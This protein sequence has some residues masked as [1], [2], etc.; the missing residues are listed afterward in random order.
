M[1]NISPQ[2]LNIIILVLAVIGA[3]F[4]LYKVAGA[5]L[6][7]VGV[8]IILGLVIYFWQGGTVDGLKGKGTEMLFKNTPIAQLEETFCA[9][10]K[11]TNAKCI[12]M[13]QPVLEDLNARLS[14][15]QIASVD[16]DADARLL[17]IRASMK[18]RQKEIRS[19]LIQ[20]KGSKYLDM[21]DR[22]V[23]EI[24]EQPAK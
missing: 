16:Q 24:R 10:E 5:A 15:D 20:K 14:V 3:G 8:V 12:C 11:A 13:V 4:L 9:G 23:D 7:T 21:V 1:E 19:C 6:R 17:E 2:T 22:A 18:N